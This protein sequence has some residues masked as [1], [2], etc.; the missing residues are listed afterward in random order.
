MT[1][2]TRVKICGLTRRQDVE[3]ALELGAD[4]VGFVLWPG[5]PRRVDLNLLKLLIQDL[6]PF[7]V[8][9]GLLVNAPRRDI[10]LLLNTVPL[11]LLQF[12]GDE[13]PEDCSGFEIGYLRAAR[14]RPGLDLIEF[15]NCFRH[16]KA[17]LLDTHAPSYG[18]TG[19]VFDW[20]LIPAGLAPRVVLSGGLNAQNVAEAVARVR[21]YAVDVSSGVEAAPGIKD[22]QRMRQFF[23]EVARADHTN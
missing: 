13:S 16:A 21:P 3:L 19:K 17:L 23:E 11:S 8:T 22:P 4:A 10:D 15:G 6:P 12:H 14:M 7:A 5:S 18:G 20:S 1:K 2:R 9:V